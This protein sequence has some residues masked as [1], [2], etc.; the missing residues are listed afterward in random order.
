MNTFSI[1]AF[2]RSV[3]QNGKGF[4]KC[5]IEQRLQINMFL[6]SNSIKKRMECTTA[7]Y[8]RR[9][10]SRHT[11]LRKYLFCTTFNL[12]MRTNKNRPQKF[13]LISSKIRSMDFVC[14]KENVQNIK[15]SKPKYTRNT[16]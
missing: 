6:G 12:R 7:E 11:G 16:I 10:F 8:K 5:S 13:P 15:V 1:Q 14:S 3:A 4:N 2:K 9:P